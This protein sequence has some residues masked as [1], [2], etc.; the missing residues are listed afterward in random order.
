M[1]KDTRWGAVFI[2]L[3]AGV[4]GGASIGKI[5]PALPALQDEFGLSLIAAGWLVSMFSVI[6]VAAGIFVGAVCDRVGAL[7]FCLLG[8]FLEMAGGAMA[9]AAHTAPLMLASRLTEGLGFLA[10][11]VSAPVLMAASS[12]PA[13]RGLTLGL[14][15]THMPAG[16]ALMIAASPFLLAAWG[17]RGTWAT[18]V[19]VMA[20]CTLL[21]AAQRSSY[22]SV[23]AGAPRSLA[24]L[25]S[26]LAK[27]V[28]WL[29][30]A[31]MACYTL[32]F[33]TVM[34]WLPT[35][36]LQ[37]RAADLAASA[38]LTAC[39]VLAN[40][41]GNVLGSWYMH[42]GV[43]RGLVIGATFAANALI[44]LG[45]FSAWLPDPARYLLVLAYGI[46]T[47]SIP[48]AVLSGGMRYARSP[49]E[50]GILQGLLVQT[51]NVG[52]FVCGPLIAAAVT[53][54]GS[55][56]AALWVLLA[57]CA[58]GLALALLIRRHEKHERL[59]P[60][61]NLERSPR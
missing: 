41:L 18:L 35:Y 10:T 50:G 49:G 25:G 34:V 47:G 36:L 37:T 15:G 44:F 39:Y 59:Y 4:A 6:A 61:G 23:A 29:L 16:G 46:V 40:A 45:V 19:A 2:A 3:A 9:M 56:D 43:S 42:R 20:A 17:W 52:T 54:H 28:P 1:A 22:A 5:S 38:L 14:W 57:A 21:L 55:W 30:G 11:V 24:N 13:H 51:S 26:S 53:W 33:T 32:C 60:N 8:L 12:S 7:R 27:P 48:P 58:L 31:A